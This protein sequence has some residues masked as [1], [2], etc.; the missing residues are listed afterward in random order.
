MHNHH[1][2]ILNAKE[3]NKVLNDFIFKASN[4][5]DTS[6]LGIKMNLNDFL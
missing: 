4:D 6:D 3:L 1:F 2:N 5:E